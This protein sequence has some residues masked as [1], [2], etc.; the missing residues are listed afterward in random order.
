MT[1]KS[2]AP[3]AKWRYEVPKDKHRLM[4]L[5]TIGGTLTKG[6]WTGEYLEQFKAWSP[7]PKEDKE[8]E[9]EIAA[10]LRGVPKTVRPDAG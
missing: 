5:L 7:M 4:L 3:V 10:Q 2:T 9:R 8:K 1:L 6:Y